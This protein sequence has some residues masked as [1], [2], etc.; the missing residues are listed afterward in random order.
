MAQ[1]IRPEDMVS[2]P[3]N[4]PDEVIEAF[5][6]LIAKYFRDGR[7]GFKQDEVVARMVRKGLKKKD[8]DSNHWL[9]VEGLYEAA[10]WIVSY[11]KSGFNETTP[12]TFTF[13][14]KR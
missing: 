3:V 11:S 10:G 4:F 13:T 5:N 2:F 9:D 1:P 6:E 12:A 8:I 14:R 7:S